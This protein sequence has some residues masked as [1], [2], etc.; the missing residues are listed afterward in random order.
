MFLYKANEANIANMRQSKI[1]DQDPKDPQEPH[2]EY[3]I[4]FTHIFINFSCA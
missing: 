4:N 2:Y 1:A 3:I